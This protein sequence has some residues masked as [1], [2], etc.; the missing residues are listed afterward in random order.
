MGSVTGSLVQAAHQSSS[1]RRL[2]MAPVI[3]C[4]E[5]CAVQGKTDVPYH[6]LGRCQWENRPVG[7]EGTCRASA[8]LVLLVVLGSC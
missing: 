4:D 3:D 8:R 7:E 6:V 1:C 2:E 5:E